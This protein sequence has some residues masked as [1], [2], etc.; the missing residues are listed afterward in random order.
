MRSQMVPV[1]CVAPAGVGVALARAR[2]LLR[3][4]DNLHADAAREAA[5]D[6]KF[7]GAYLAALRGAATVLALY[8]KPRR[9]GQRTRNAWVLLEAVS[10]EWARWS[11]EF[12][13]YSRKRAAL[14]AGISSVTR[15]DAERLYELV[16][17]FLDSVHETVV[18]F[19][20]SDA[21]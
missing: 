20:A 1:S 4:A 14:E 13:E 16:T 9:R 8:D 17:E 11:G 21:A 2:E 19:S 15:A 5:P 18:T 12:V 10:G 7:R 3:R 6:D